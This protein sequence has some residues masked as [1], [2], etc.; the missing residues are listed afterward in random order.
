MRTRNTLQRLMVSCAVAAIA[1]T[2]FG[3]A[4]AFAQDSGETDTIYVVAQRRSEN[5]Q[6]VPIAATAIGG[7]RMQEL[8]SGGADV[9]AL[10]GRAPGLNVESSNG[11]VAPRFYI[12][13]LGNTDFDL[14]ASQPVSVLMDDVVMENVALKSFPIFD[15]QQVE[16][17]RGPQ[18]TLYGRNTPA[19]IVHFRSVRPSDEFDANVFGSYGSLG[20]ASLEGAIGGAIA[21]GVSARGSFAYRRRDDWVDNTFNGTELGGYD[22]FAGRVQV[23]LE[24]TENFD[25]LLNVHARS[26]EGTSTLF[27]ANILSS[28]SNELNSNFDRD[29]VSYNQ[30]G[31]NPQEYDQLGGSATLSYDFG[32][33]T[34]TSISAYETL[35]GRSRGDIDGGV[36]GVGPGFIPF[37]SD[38]QDSIDDLTQFTQ[39]VRLAS[40]A[41]PFN[42]QVGAYYFDSDLTVTTVGP[43]GFPPST[44][45]NHTNTSWAVFGQAGFD[46]SD[47]L[48][49]TAGV[50]YTSDEK[51][52]VGVVTAFPVAPV[53]VSDE[54]VSWDLSATYAATPDVNLYARIAN[55]FRAPT[56]QARDVA[57]FN[58][59]STAD[60]E[61][62]QSY[63]AGV[64][65]D[66]LDRT[67]RLNAAVYYYTIED[68]QFSAIG[69]GGNFNQLVNA[70]EGEGYGFEVEGEFIVTDNLSVNASYTYNHTEI[71]DAD[72]VIAPCGSGQCTVLDDTDGLGNAFVSGNPFPQAPEYTFD[73]SLNY[74]RPLASGATL[75]ASTDWTVRGPANIFLYDAIEYRM[76]AQAEGGL[77]LGYRSADDRYEFAVFGRNITDAENVIGG[78][79]FNNNT[80]F[81]NEPRVWGV[82]LSASFN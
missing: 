66:L 32:G 31:G 60:S 73:V 8:L 22:D 76:D 36:A 16:V 30:G 10:A 54:R 79:D 26:Y 68:Q 63:E 29:R 75:F 39:E 50:R 15:V 1:I 9:L 33:M 43:F 12:R 3:A 14:A 65:S 55:G 21:S 67:V 57:F 27:R 5:L 45:L 81:V 37:D 74:E 71:Q 2:A 52:L 23:L 48:T 72:L 58:P 69:G 70:D 24:P 80:A 28:G 82:S 38:T 59:P 34:L 46:L 17:L 18:G 53:N 49:V 61:V 47:Q 44:T 25:A 41:G 35:D 20:T 64:K 6:E 62:I 77:R 78:I 56:I 11:R 13:G 40:E 4:P 19:G 7:E 42:W 51:D